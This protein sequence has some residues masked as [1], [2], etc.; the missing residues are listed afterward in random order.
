MLKEK[1]AMLASMKKI[2]AESE[3]TTKEFDVLKEQIETLEDRNKDYKNKL[4]NVERQDKTIEDLKAKAQKLSSDLKDSKL[5]LKEFESIHVVALNAD[6]EKLKGKLE[7]KKNLLKNLLKMNMDI[8]TISK[9]TGLTKDELE[10]L[11]KEI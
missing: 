6:N 1:E 8:E 7:E 11:K 10:K 3:K 9:A 5:K 4:S 2:Q